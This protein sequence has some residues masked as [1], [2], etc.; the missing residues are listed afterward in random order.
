MYITVRPII[1]LKSAWQNL[2]K[3][4]I[5]FEFWPRERSFCLKKLSS[6]FFETPFMFVCNVCVLTSQT[7]SLSSPSNTPC[8]LSLTSG[9]SSWLQ[10]SLLQQYLLQKSLLQQSLLQQSLLQQSL[11]QQSLLQQSLLQQYLLQQS[12]LQQYLFCFQCLGS[13]PE[14]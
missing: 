4:T 5:T 6:H 13:L 1:F 10:Q 14:Q 2:F 7:P 9:V 3:T 12:L 8:Y 11:L